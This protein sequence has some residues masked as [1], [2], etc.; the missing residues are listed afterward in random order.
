MYFVEYVIRPAWAGA[1]ALSPTVT[2]RARIP[3]V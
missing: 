2:V 3:R 1:D